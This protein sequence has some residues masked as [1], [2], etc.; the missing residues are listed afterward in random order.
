MS[1]SEAWKR[2]RAS[3]SEKYREWYKDWCATHVDQVRQL[4]RDYYYRTKANRPW[5]IIYSRIKARCGKKDRY[6]NI[7]RHLT[8]KELEQLWLR[9]GAWDM[10]KP[11]IHRKNSKDHYTFDNCEFMEYNEHQR[12]HIVDYNKGEGRFNERKWHHKVKVA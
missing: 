6:K 12:M 5:V 8:V 9:D 10:V 11:C 4:R 7:E 2:Y 1:N 3:H